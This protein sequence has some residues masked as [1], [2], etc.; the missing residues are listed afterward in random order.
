[1]AGYPCEMNEIL[2]LCK[3]KNITIIEDCAHALGTF[4]KNKHAGNFGISGCF[5][6]T[7]QSK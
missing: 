3:K 1:M 6:F 7:Q 2:K 5:S 4:Y